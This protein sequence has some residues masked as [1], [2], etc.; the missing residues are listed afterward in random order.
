MTNGFEVDP[1]ALTRHAAE[2]PALAGRAGAIHAELSAALQAAGTC[3]GDD[4]TGRAFAAGH[5]P[6]A[7]RTLTQLSALGGRLADVGDRFTTTA[8]AYQQSDQL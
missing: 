2:F 5:V 7:G 4:E 1:A 6:P 8:R 3:W